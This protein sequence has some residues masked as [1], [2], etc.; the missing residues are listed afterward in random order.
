MDRVGAGSGHG[1]DAIARL[2]SRRRRAPPPERTHPAAGAPPR[3][4]PGTPHPRSV[5]H[6]LDQRRRTG[7]RARRSPGRSAG[8][9]PRSSG[10]TASAA[11]SSSSM[12]P[13]A[14][15]ATCGRGRPA[16][17]RRGR[18]APAPTRAPRGTG[19]RAGS[20]RR[21]SRRRARASWGRSP[22]CTRGCRRGRGSAGARRRSWN[23]GVLDVTLAPDHSARIAPIDARSEASARRLHPE[24]EERPVAGP[25]PE[26]HAAAGD[27]VHRRG[28]RRRDRGMARQRVGDG[29]PE[30]QPRRRHAQRAS[31]R[32]RS[33]GRAATSR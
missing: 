16:S 23:A 3:R 28:R 33:C 19:R 9:M 21:R 8:T 25:D 11:S 27:L 5:A 18:R 29:R 20:R 26:D 7:P 32:R 30:Q 12:A 15:T 13:Y 10:R 1:L 31:G 14:N 17:P 4:P 22:R 24:R 2:T 6:L